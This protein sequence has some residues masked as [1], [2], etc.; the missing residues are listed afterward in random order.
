MAD[1][2]LRTQLVYHRVYPDA[3][4]KWGWYGESHF[5][6]VK[7]EQNLA[8]AVPTAPPFYL[9]VN[10]PASGYLFYSFEPGWIGDW[11]LSPARQFMAI[12]SGACEVETSDGNVKR[13]GPGD[14]IL[15][16]DTWGKG[17]RLRNISEDYLNFFVVR[18]PVT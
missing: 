1:S 9:S 7:V 12:L 4:A 15:L 13:F 5:D 17:H 10:K 18:I 8:N 3:R 14:I 2:T 11:H 16:E 6:I